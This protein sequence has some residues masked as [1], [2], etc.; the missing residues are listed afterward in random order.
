MSKEYTEAY[1]WGVRFAASLITKPIEWGNR[2]N[3]V[4][5]SLVFAYLSAIFGLTALLV[6]VVCITSALAFAIVHAIRAVWQAVAAHVVE[7]VDT[8]WRMF[9]ALRERA[10][11][12]RA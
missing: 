11:I 5:K 2:G 3:N 1:G 6:V 8:L 7:A 4:V 9:R 10:A 12:W